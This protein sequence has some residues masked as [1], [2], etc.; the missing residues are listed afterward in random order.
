MTNAPC[1][2]YR[3]RCGIFCFQRRT[4]LSLRQRF[5]SLPIFFRKSLGTRNKSDALQHARKLSVMFDELQ[6]KY[7]KDETEYYSAIKML[8]QYEELRISHLVMPAPTQ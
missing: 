1:F 8:Q 7:F 6:K 5:S 3:N 4:P 2:L